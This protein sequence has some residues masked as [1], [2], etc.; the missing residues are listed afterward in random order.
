MS[1]P[2][3]TVILPVR[4]EAASIEA[5]LDS[6]L[7]Q[8]VDAEL[9]VVVAE[10]RS[11]DGTAEILSARAAR[12]RR[13]R[14]VDNPGRG[15]SAGLNAALAAARGRYV[16]RLDGHSAME[17]GYVQ[18]LLDHLR[19]ARCEAAGGRVEAV[20]TSAFG[21]AVAAAHGSRF[22]IGNASHH[23]RSEP[24]LIDHLSFGSYVTER[25]RALGGWDEGFACNEDYELNFRYRAAGGRI[26]LDPAFVGRWQVRETPR[27]LA[28]QYFGYG[29]WRVR[30]LA[31]HPSSLGPRWLAPPTLVL[32]LTVGALF[33]WTAWG[34]LLLGATALAYALFLAV[35]ALTLAR[36]IG[37]RLV[38]RAALALA[39]MHL[40]WGVGFLASVLSLPLQRRR[41][42]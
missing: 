37:L 35:G 10:G 29:W 34:R 6:V 28:R 19:S 20:G 27:A 2:E 23:Y 3:V 14:V 12:D 15:I 36:R 39:V 7:A 42:R 4:N 18:G 30:T 26:L 33:S 24:A 17:P 5:A 21:R 11:E 16:V 8:E 25:L 41:A 13:I 22:G 38:G 9:E 31:R 1:T 32:A 40:S